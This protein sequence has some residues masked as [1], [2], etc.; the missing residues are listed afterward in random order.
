MSKIIKHA[1]VKRLLDEKDVDRLI[2]VL[3]YGGTRSMQMDAAVALGRLHDVKAVKPLIEAM[4]SQYTWFGIRVHAARSLRQIEGKQAKKALEEAAE[5]SDSPDVRE[6]A[7]Q[8]LRF[9][10]S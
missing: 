9:W 8:I 10:T 1:D 6:T 3:K 2:Q 4:N 5:N 7:K